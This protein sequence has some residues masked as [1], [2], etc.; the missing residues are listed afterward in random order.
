[1]SHLTDNQF[2]PSAERI[3]LCVRLNNVGKQA[4]DRL[5]EDADFGKKINFSDEAPFKLGGYVNKQNCRIWGTKV[6]HAYIEKPT[7]PKRVTVWS[8]FWLRGLIGPF[9]FENE[10]GDAVTVNGDRYRA[11]MNEFWLRTIEENDIGNIWFQQDSTACHTGEATRDILGPV[12][13]DC[14]V[15]CRIKLLSIINWKDCTFK[16]KKKLEKIYSSLFFKYFQK[17]KVI[18]RNLY[19]YMYNL[20]FFVTFVIFYFYKHNS[21]TGMGN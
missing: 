17:K 19:L 2:Y 5:T 18:W 7:H 21:D 16:W 15:S 14:I 12:F 13:E 10:Q 6:P 4:C 11:M 1:M 20:P 3:W 8:G 9:L